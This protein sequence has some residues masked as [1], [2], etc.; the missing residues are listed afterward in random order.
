MLRPTLSPGLYYQ[1]VGRGFR[2]HPNK[3]D[4]LVL[5]FGGNILRHGPVDALQIKPPPDGTGE[6]PAKE[7]P[8]CR[9][10]IHA[11]YAVC[12]ECGYEFPEPER[13]K[14]DR[15]ASEA[16]ILTGQATVTEYPVQ[17]IRYSVHTKRDAPPDAPRTLRVEYRIGW[18]I[19]RSEWVCFE[20]T[21]YARAKAE[22]WWRRRTDLPVPDTV[23]EAVEIA[24]G[25]NLAEPVAIT[26]RSVS[27]QKYDQIAGYRFAVGPAPDAA[28][29]PQE[30]SL[31]DEPVPF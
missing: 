25:A 11:A 1:M 8:G 13:Q 27:G 6:A 26:V 23:D 3:T 21:G 14:H 22:A 4:C 24:A 16:A 9:A 5:D 30:G 31:D 15:H 28:F 12:P 10:V 2:L 20:H 7:C 18:N 19:W 17:E 29:A